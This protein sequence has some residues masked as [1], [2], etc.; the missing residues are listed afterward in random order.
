MGKALGMDTLGDDLEKGV[1]D[2]L[3]EVDKG[4]SA[5]GTSFGGVLGG[6][7]TGVKRLGAAFMAN[8]ILFIAGIALA[9]TKAFFGFKKEVTKTSYNTIKKH[10]KT[11]LII[12]SPFLT[13]HT[14]WIFYVNLIFFFDLLVCNYI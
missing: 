1:I 6:L 3:D 4:S 11:I 2:N 10:K 14:V 12:F 9:A 13:Q 5:L 7:T 8:P